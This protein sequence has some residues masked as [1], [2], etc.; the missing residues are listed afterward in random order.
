MRA[1]L[2]LCVAVFLAVVGAADA[3][4]GP[5][6]WG[7]R[8]GLTAAGFKKANAGFKNDG[9]R[10]VSVSGYVLPG[11]VRYSAIWRHGSSPAWS[12]DLALSAGAWEN[13]L[14]ARRQQ[15]YRP[16]FVSGYTLNGKARFAVIW[17]KRTG[18]WVARQGL[19]TAQNKAYLEEVTKQGFRPAHVTAYVVGGAAR[20]AVIYD[21]RPIAPQ[22]DFR[23][24][25]SGVGFR[26]RQRTNAR[27]GRRLITVSAY[28]VNGRD[29]YAALWQ[30]RSGPV[31]R[32]RLAVP[33]ASNPLVYDVDR[34]QGSAPVHVQVYRSG[35]GLRINR[36]WHSP[37]TAADLNTIED[38]FNGFLTKHKLAGMQVAIGFEGQ[39]RYASGFGMANKE[40]GEAMGPHHRM[41]IG[42]VSKS[43]TSAAA[44]KLVQ[45]RKLAIDEKVFGPGGILSDVAVP[46][47][48]RSLENATVAHFLEHTAG[49]PGIPD[50]L[51]C[52]AG[53]ESLAERIESEMQEFADTNPPNPVLGDPGQ[54]FNYENF[55]FM[56]V[57][58]V[59]ERRTGK[60]YR[61]YVRE[62]LFAPAGIKGDLFKM[63]PYQPQSGEA[64]G[65]DPN[66]NYVA[67]SNPCE[68]EP[69]GVGAGGWAL[70]MKDLLLHLAN[71]D[72]R[73]GGPGVP[74]R[75]QP[76]G[77]AHHVEREQQRPRAGMV[78]ELD[79]RVVRR[80]HHVRP[81]SPRGHGRRLGASLGASERLSVRGQRHG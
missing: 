61:D 7:S 52:P 31:V 20:F 21:R 6:P 11:G 45:Q 73:A 56:I 76:R 29:R 3:A 5:T 43:I 80:V 32:P 8:T 48:M 54:V 46:A 47:S 71:S 17:E 78:E 19:T 63:G 35:A 74:E 25:M 62:Q 4:P 27:A 57:E 68:D 40:T 67:W 39:L 9:F 75:R 18:A 36:I 55:G 26:L 22:F 10:L 64:K 16:T 79:P 44:F 58:L 33:Y 49:L 50:P 77:H 65:Y 37:F 28:H 81:G 69:P 23:T 13:A 42:S 41:R 51:N 70:S 15:G 34:Y 66:G 60:S 1:C 12:A 24:G 2:G 30:R 38:A 59:I 72:G 14:A 53:T